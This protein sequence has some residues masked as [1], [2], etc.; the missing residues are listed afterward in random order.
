MLLIKKYNIKMEQH[1]YFNNKIILQFYLDFFKKVDFKTINIKDFKK[2]FIFDTFF[3]FNN[4][5]KKVD[6]NLIYYKNDFGAFVFK[7]DI[8]KL[9]Y[10][11]PQNYFKN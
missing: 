10:D 6:K 3:I 7:N 1:N 9:F 11:A 5:I 4:D 2:H 8:D